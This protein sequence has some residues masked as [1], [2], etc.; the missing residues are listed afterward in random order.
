MIDEY[1]KH[2]VEWKKLIGETLRRIWEFEE[3]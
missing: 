2:Q 1:L 3:E